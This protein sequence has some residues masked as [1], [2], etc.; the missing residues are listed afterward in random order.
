MC[1][2]TQSSDQTSHAY[3]ADIINHGETECWTE[4]YKNDNRNCFLKKIM[5]GLLV[6]TNKTLEV[7]AHSPG[8]TFTS[9]SIVVSGLDMIQIS[10]T[11]SF[12]T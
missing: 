1:Q 3:V 11:Q 2:A 4:T 10:L 12:R 6:S 7:H 8:K 9:K 5:N